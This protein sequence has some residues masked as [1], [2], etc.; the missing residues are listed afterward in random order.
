MRTVSYNMYRKS[1]H[2]FQVQIPTT[3]HPEDRTVYEIMRKTLSSRLGQMTIWRTRFACCV[4]TATN[5]HSEYV[6]FLTAFHR[7]HCLRYTYIACFVETEMQL[8]NHKN[9]V[10]WP[11]QNG[12]PLPMVSELRRAPSR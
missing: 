8:C 1:K 4:T 5:T 12:R 6:I 9:T 3:P 10:Y 11:T 7:Q 2:T